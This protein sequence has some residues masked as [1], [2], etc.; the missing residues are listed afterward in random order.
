MTIYGEGVTV[1]PSGYDPLLEQIAEFFKA[2]KPPV[3]TEETIKV[4]AFRSAA[5]E[6]AAQGGAAISI[7]ET[8]KRARSK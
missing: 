7:A 4:Y 3:S 1:R 2:G 6:S 5:V 8:I